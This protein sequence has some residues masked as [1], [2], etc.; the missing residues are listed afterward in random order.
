MASKPLEVESHN[1][2]QTESESTK[3]EEDIS[4]SRDEILDKE[5]A[6]IKDIPRHQEILQTF[7]CKLFKLLQ[8]SSMYPNMY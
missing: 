4:E 5:F 7:N 8:F 1:A 3:T 2:E 6:K